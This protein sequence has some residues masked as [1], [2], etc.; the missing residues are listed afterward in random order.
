MV[1][2]KALLDA[3]INHY[4]DYHTLSSNN[5]NDYSHHFIILNHDQASPTNHH[6]L[7]LPIVIVN[8]CQ[9]S[10]IMMIIPG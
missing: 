8:H 5:A 10:L 2:D 3:T 7:L 1:D 4:N 6:W 9:P